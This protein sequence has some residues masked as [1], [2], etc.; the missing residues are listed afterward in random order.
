MGCPLSLIVGSEDMMKRHSFIGVVCCILVA[1]CTRD[2]PRLHGSWKSDAE[3]SMAWNLEHADLTP[4]QESGLA[5]MFGHM[6]VTYSPGGAGLV[7]ME[8]YALAVGTNTHSMPGFTKTATFKVIG[9]T[10]KTTTVKTTS[11][12]MAGHV[13]TVHFDGPDVYWLHLNE[14]EPET[15]AREYFRR[16]ERPNQTGGR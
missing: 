15:S 14:D 9:R 2:D 11:G 16:M 13:A 4:K 12:F 7:V 6:T 8:P 3:R 1:G 5:Q 10:D